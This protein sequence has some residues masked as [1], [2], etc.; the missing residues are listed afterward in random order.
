MQSAEDWWSVAIAALGG[1]FTA[2]LAFLAKGGSLSQQIS[3][4]TIELMNKNSE[5]A[6]KMENKFDRRMGALEERLR[7][8][9]RDMPR[10][11]NS[12]RS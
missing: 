5:L 9:E 6:E 7:I 12:L 3:D 1:F 10:R 11:D 8:V 4:Q 2:G